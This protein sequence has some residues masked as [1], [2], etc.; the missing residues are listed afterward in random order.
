MSAS[1][2][3]Q[4]I[5]EVG[6]P[7]YLILTIAKVAVEISLFTVSNMLCVYYRRYVHETHSIHE[8]YRLQ[9][10]VVIYLRRV[11]LICVSFY[12][13]AVTIRIQLLE[14]I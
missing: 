1:Q 14:R 9:G 3:A 2:Q 7:G 12:W 11:T 4:T 10:C 6:T 13:F 8:M 5:G